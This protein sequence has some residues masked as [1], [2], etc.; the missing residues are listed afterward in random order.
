MLG[1]ESSSSAQGSTSFSQRSALASAMATD[2]T[3]GS[4]AVVIFNITLEKRGYENGQLMPHPSNEPL[5]AV[6][7]SFDARRTHKKSLRFNCFPGAES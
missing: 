4:V 3:L 7:S 2:P 5:G 1:P 6:M